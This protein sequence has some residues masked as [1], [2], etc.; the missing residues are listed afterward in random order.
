MENLTPKAIEQLK[1]ALFRQKEVVL[2][3][4]HN[5]DGDA[6]GAA[7]AMAMYLQQKGIGSCVISPNEF[8][9]FLKWMPWADKVHI[10]NESADFCIKKI[11]EASFVFCLDFNHPGRIKQ[12]QN[13]LEE[14][15][16]Y[17]A[18][19]DHHIDPSP[20]FDFIY[21]V[22]EE[23]SSTCELVHQFIAKYLNDKDKITKEMAECLYV[24][25]ITDTG[26]FSYNCDN[27]STYEVLSQLIQLHIN[28]E[29]IH[30]KVYDTYSENRVRLLG[31][32]LSERLH[33]MEEFGTSYIYA[34]REDLE[35]FNFKPGDTEGI[36]N[37]GIS[38]KNV[39]FTAFFSEKDE[40][41]R[42]S[43]RSKGDFDVD[44]FARQHFHGG[45]HKHA[46][47]GE[48]DLSMEETLAYF[49][50]TLKAYKNLI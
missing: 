14:S 6:L 5:P 50:S 11:K 44:A 13:A 40:N 38:M 34:T 10:A 26:S 17:K 3:M 48:S 18:L 21:S 35:R 31:F 4:H 49:K 27:A 41:I 43:F 22:K 39:R 19:I 47:G 15:K 29:E 12:L 45:G 30:R 23:T 33:V 20:M 2:L 1:Q 9:D 7:L 25:M 16:A 32:C 28:G 42:V 46:A 36:V 24:G 8:P 37:Y